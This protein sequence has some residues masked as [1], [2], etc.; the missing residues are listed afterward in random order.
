MVVPGFYSAR[1]KSDN[2]TTQPSMEHNIPNSSSMNH[3]EAKSSSDRKINEGNATINSGSN[4]TGR[5][6]MI[7]DNHHKDPAPDDTQGS[8]M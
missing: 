3:D 6:V 2:K 5:N 7:A 4:S 1:K 8:N